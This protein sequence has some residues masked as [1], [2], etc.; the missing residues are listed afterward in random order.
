[1]VIA[2]PGVWAEAI[3]CTK[4]GI[5]SG[6]KPPLAMTVRILTLPAGLKANARVNHAV[7]HI[8]S[9]VAESDHDGR[10]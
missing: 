6:Q 9:E 2:R 8:R 1:M 10:Q 4:Q 5:A 7:Q 3:S